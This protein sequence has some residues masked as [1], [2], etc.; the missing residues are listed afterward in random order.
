MNNYQ[1]DV[2]KKTV[3]DHPYQWLVKMQLPGPARN[4]KQKTAAPSTT[5]GMN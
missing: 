3:Q 1:N 5:Y 4:L 2:W